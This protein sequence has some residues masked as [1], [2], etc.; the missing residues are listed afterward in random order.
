[1][2]GSK[3]LYNIF[4]NEGS[5]GFVTVIEFCIANLIPAGSV[6]LIGSQCFENIA[7]TVVAAASVE[8]AVD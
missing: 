8:N 4:L 1:M 6:I 7:Q 3:L 2:P 5:K